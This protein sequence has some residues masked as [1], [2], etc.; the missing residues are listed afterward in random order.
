[1]ETQPR[2][3]DNMIKV[4][5]EDA[6]KLVRTLTATLKMI[7]KSTDR[8]VDVVWSDLLEYDHDRPEM[9]RRV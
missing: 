5:R 1:M 8:R 2:T 9:I 4:S 3:N 6:E 7:A